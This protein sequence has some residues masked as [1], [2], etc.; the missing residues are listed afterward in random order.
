MDGP[1]SSLARSEIGFG[2]DLAKR[3]RAA[4][5]FKLIRSE[6][7]AVKLMRAEELNAWQEARELTT[8]AAAQPKSWPPNSALL[9]GRHGIPLL[10]GSSGG[11]NACL[12]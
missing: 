6:E 3:P 2:E 1:F 12:R 10:P 9:T 8:A 11:P 5:C 7:Q 4:A